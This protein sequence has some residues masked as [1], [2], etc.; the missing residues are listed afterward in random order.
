MPGSIVQVT[1]NGIPTKVLPAVFYSS[2][3]LAI[4]VWFTIPADYE[5]AAI[6]PNGTVSKAVQLTV[7]NGGMQSVFG[8]GTPDIQMAFP[9]SLDTQFSG[10]VWLIGAEFT[11]GCV[12]TVTVQ[13]Q[14]PYVAPLLFVNDRTVGWISTIPLAGDVTLQVTNPTLLTSQTIT[15]TVQGAQQPA[16]APVVPQ[17][18][19]P[20]QVSSPFVGS[21]HLVGA[22]I[23]QGAYAELRVPGGAMAMT[24]PLIR[25]SSA[26]AWLTLVYPPVGSYELR[27]VNPTGD[28]SPWSAFDVR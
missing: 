18:S 6:A 10:T 7:P 15:L 26:E 3:L 24:V 14:L 4:E 13:G 28:A 2:E 19:A 11:P 8:M 21:V 9:P 12:A 25:V 17:V 23:Q 16:G 5:F 1:V 22:D 20:A 27:V